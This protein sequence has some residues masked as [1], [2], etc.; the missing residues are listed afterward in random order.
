M[1]FQWIFLAFFLVFM[2]SEVVKALYKPMIKNLLRLICIPVAFIITYVMQACGLFQLVAKKAIE[3]LDLASKLGQYAGLIDYLIAFAST[4]L[5]SVLFVAVFYIVFWLLKLI[6]VN[7]IANSIEASRRKQKKAQ[8]KEAIKKEKAMVKQAIVENEKRLEEQL[9][10]GEDE[11]ENAFSIAYKDLDEDEIEDLVEKRVEEEKKIKT[12]TGF[13]AESLENRVV[14]LIS[15]AVSGI[16]IFGITLMPV[17]YTMGILTSVT[18]SLANSDADDSNVYK[19]VA[20]VDEHIV[21]PYNSSFVVQLYDSMALVDL[22]NSAARRSGTIE[23]D[24]GEKI[25][26]DDVVRTVLTHGVSAAAQLTSQK[27][28]YKSLGNDIKAITSNPLVS[29]LLSDAILGK[30]QALEVP[31]VEDGDILGGLKAGFIKHYKSVDEK[32]FA[33]DIEFISD[34]V[35]VLAKNG[36]LSGILNGGDVDLDSMLSDE[37]KLGDVIESM[38]GLSVFEPVMSDLLR[39]TIETIGSTLAIPADDGEAYDAFLADLIETMGKYNS[40]YINISNV[41]SFVKGCAQSA[42]HLVSDH[43]T[44]APTEASSFVEYLKRW[45]DIQSVFMNAS[46]DRSLAYFTITVDGQ[47]YILDMGNISSVEDVADMKKATITAVANASEYGNKISPLSHLI[48]YLACLSHSSVDQAYINTVLTSY[49]S[50]T[51]DEYQA[52][53]DVATSLM[54][55]DTFVSH[56]V[57]IEKMTDSLDFEDWTREEKKNDGRLSASIILSFLDISESL[58]AESSDI[59][60]MLDQFVVL[61]RTMDLMKQTSCMKDLPPLLLEGLVKNGQ[62]GEILTPSIV[63]QIID[64]V[65][66][67]EDLSY[68]GYMKSLVDTFKIALQ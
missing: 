37:E 43:A 58:G 3:L 1:N 67:N 17:F 12:K 48:N 5:S 4:A 45:S 27:T 50:S 6:H 64:K 36:L 2:I 47:L 66:S 51:S 40:S 28:E 61:G 49:V 35:V 7:L 21:A 10:A 23:L 33:E 24:N 55:K 52:C 32:T 20:V 56:G 59:D 13:F 39:G 63:N 9:E 11:A 62:I 38:A 41:N 19:M 25:Y 26:V 68:E 60:T 34:A 14:S 22:M 15:G 54:N 16:L 8:L 42:T 29:T 65:E 31:A 18:D 44:A 53:K 30:L 57:T 46:E